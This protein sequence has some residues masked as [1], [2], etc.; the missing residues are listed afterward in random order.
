MA[1]PCL[2]FLNVGIPGM[3]WRAWLFLENLFGACHVSLH[4]KTVEG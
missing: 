4:C 2:S 3:S 1:T